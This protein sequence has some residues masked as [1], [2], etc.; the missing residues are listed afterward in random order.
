M[1]NALPILGAE[2]MVALTVD[3][4]SVAPG[5]AKPTVVMTTATAETAPALG[6]NLHQKLVSTTSR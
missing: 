5:D 4:P 1:M 3:Q 6:L 2:G